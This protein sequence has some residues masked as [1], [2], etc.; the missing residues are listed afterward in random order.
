MIHNV[1]QSSLSDYEKFTYKNHTYYFLSGDTN[2][3]ITYKNHCIVSIMSAES[4]NI[5]LEIVA[6]SKLNIK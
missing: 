1:N 3:L 2:T 4:K 6:S 5:L